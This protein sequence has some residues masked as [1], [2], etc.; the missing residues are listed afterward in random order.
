MP[1]W[2]KN[3]HQFVS[4]DIEKN[5]LVISVRDLFLQAH[6]PHALLFTDLVNCLDPTGVLSHEQRIEQ[7]ETCFKILQD[8]HESTLL[9]F[10]K[11]VKSYFP[12]TGKELALMCDFVAKHAG[13]NNLQNFALDLAKS[14]QG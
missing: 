6:D 12:E 11:L 14:E 9:N 2:V 3:A 7:L 8:K 10:K 4:N 13:S 5:K 1:Q